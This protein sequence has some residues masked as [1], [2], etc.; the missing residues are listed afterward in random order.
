MRVHISSPEQYPE[1]WT[2]EL[3][4]GDSSDIEIWF[5][6]YC[7]YWWHRRTQGQAPNKSSQV[8]PPHLKGTLAFATQKITSFLSPERE[9]IKQAKHDFFPTCVRIWNRLWHVKT[10]LKP[11]KNENFLNIKIIIDVRPALANKWKKKDMFI[12]LSPMTVQR[13][14]VLRLD[15]S[16]FLGGIWFCLKDVKKIEYKLFLSY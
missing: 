9:T 10:T 11:T 16:G 14:F 12:C 7:Y 3:A 6:G 2:L 4:V 5:R 1:I 15:L 13:F 8:S